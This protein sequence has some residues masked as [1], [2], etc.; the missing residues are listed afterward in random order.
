MDVTLVF[1]A[2]PEL[3]GFPVWTAPLTT[4]LLATCLAAAGHDVDLLDT[5]LLG[6]SAEGREKA[7]EARLNSTAGDVV[8]I[9]FMSHSRHEAF[10]VAALCKSAGRIT[11]G[12]GPHATVRPEE[13]IRSGLFDIVICGEGEQTLVSVIN[14]L[15]QLRRSDRKILEGQPYDLSQYPPLRDFA[16]YQDVYQRPASI[17]LDEAATITGLSEYTLREALGKG[18]GAAI[19]DID[20]Q[21][22]RRLPEEI[23]PARR[24]FR[25]VYLELGRGCP[26]RCHYCTI[27][28]DWFSPKVPRARP[29][30]GVAS[31]LAHFV[32]EYDTNYVIIVDSIGPLY[33]EFRSFA[34]LMKTEFPHVEYSFNCTATHFTEDIASLLEGADCLIWFGFETASENLLRLLRKPATAQMNLQAAQL[35]N[36]YGIRFGANL[37]LGVPGETDDDYE[38]TMDFLYTTQPYSPN[39]NILTPLPGTSM[40]DACL[41]Q[42]I[43]RDPA[44]YRTWSAADIRSRGCGPIH[45]VD[46]ERVLDYYEK[47]LALDRTGEAVHVERGCHMKPLN[48]AGEA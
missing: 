27:Q 29:L 36:D 17:P 43:L 44:D 38:R 1:V 40:Y 26:F 45:G 10:R 37:L 22:L 46:Y 18:D 3:V 20:V 31:E 41:A 7:L 32:H 12:G 19:N 15:H 25:S 47:M 16:T 2:E 9:S 28:N 33:E 5:R 8:G 14:D 39:P 24:D 48:A 34:Y 6:Q 13:L 35:C 30:P 42:G 23:F 21:S 4:P 11:I